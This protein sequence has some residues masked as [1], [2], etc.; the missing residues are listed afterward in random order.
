MIFV[1]AILKY[2]DLHFPKDYAP[3]FRKL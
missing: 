3:S 2:A 1:Y